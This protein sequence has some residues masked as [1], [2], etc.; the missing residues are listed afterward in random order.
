MQPNFLAGGVGKL[1]TLYFPSE[2]TQCKGAILHVPAFAEEMNKSR[3]MVVKQAREMARNGH[4]VLIVDLY[5]TGDS[6]GEF[7]EASWDIWVE[8]VLLLVDW[9]VQNASPNITLWGLRLGGLLA[10][11]C[12]Q[13]NSF[14]RKLLLWQ[15]VISGEQ[16]MQQF[17]RLRIAAS[18]M[19]NSEKE[20]VKSLKA[21]L[22]KGELLE[23]AGY[24]LPPTL[25]SSIANTNMSTLDV[26]GLK[27][28]GWFEVNSSAKSLTV[29]SQKLV[30]HWQDDFHLPVTSQ[31]VEGK[32]FWSN[33]E[34]VWA[35][36]LIIQTNLLLSAPIA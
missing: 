6:E 10:V 33:Q 26:T 2:C 28:A 24:E 20:T 34:I 30:A 4:S 15:P 22:E 3:H 1:F 29:P 17:L 32:Q 14:I 12:A 9:L 31:T 16:F 19:G 8:D 36:N 11:V 27:S 23:V 25:F 13:Q 18:I 5:G 35:E 7:A 21:I